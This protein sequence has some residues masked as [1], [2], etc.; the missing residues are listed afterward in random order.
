VNAPKAFPDNIVEHYNLKEKAL[1][2]YVY[3]EI[4]HGMYGLPQ[5]GILA[6]KLL[7][8]R[9]GRHGYF[10]VQHTPGLWKHISRPVWFNL[11][12]D[13]FGIK[14]IGNEISNTSFRHYVLKRMKLSKTGQAIYTAESSSSGTMVHDGSTLQC[15]S[16]RLK[17]SRDIAIH[18]H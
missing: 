7:Q 10:E 4:R 11:C 2:G 13:N 12:I 18:H 3:M 16:M 17:I 1:N 5:A 6:N 9:L 8:K 14:Y 15:L